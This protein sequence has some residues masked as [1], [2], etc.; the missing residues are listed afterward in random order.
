MK[1][2]HKQTASLGVLLGVAF[3]LGACGDRAVSPDLALLPG[4]SATF[5]SNASRTG[6]Y[7]APGVPALTGVKWTF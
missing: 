1:Q 6:V 4:G 3:A 7:A 5:R 2:L